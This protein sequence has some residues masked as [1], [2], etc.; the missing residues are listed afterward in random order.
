MARGREAFDHRAW[1]DAF[2]YLSSVD[3]GERLPAEDLERL[4]IAAFLIGRDESSDVAWERAYREWLGDGNLTRAA[5][6]AFWLAFG[7]LDR[8]EMT[9]GEGW[10]A[11]ASRLLEDNDLDCA[12]RG[13]VLI[14]VALRHLAENEAAV[15]Y[16]VFEQ[17]GAI[18]VRFGDT[19]LTTLSLMGR[20]QSLIQ[21]GKIGE[22]LK[23]LDETMVA[24]TTGEVSPPVGGRVYCAVID[25]CLEV[26]DVSRAQDWTTAL[27]RWCESQTGL[28]QFAGVCRLHRSELLQL[29][30]DWAGAIDEVQCAVQRITA[31]HPAVGLAHYQQAELHRLRGEFGL[32]EAAYQLASRCRRDPH[33]GLALMWLARGEVDVAVAAIARL[34][35]DQHDP[36]RAQSRPPHWRTRLRRVKATTPEVLAAVVEIMLAAGDVDAARRAADELVEL[37][38]V[39]AAP[40]V[41]ALADY[42]DGAVLLGEGDAKSAIDAAACVVRW[43]ASV[44]GTV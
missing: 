19:D 5:G 6:S 3:D 17:A 31:G 36:G 12:E 38:A 27:T 37:A 21:L 20:G 7:L 23:L 42:A 41:G 13:Y 33:P 24:V 35:A 34:H 14:P 10:L 28:V 4:G 11:R 25:S 39:N 26:F 29:H 16:A 1:I 40:V 15:A 32:A 8:G 30:G 9:R 2:T 43:V 44:A 22:G 18:A